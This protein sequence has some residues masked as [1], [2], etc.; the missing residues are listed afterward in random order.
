MVIVAGISV[1]VVFAL[2]Y[3]V[4]TTYTLRVRTDELSQSTRAVASG[5]AGSIAD[6]GSVQDELTCQLFRVEAGLIG[7][8]LAV[9]DPH[10]T[11]LYESS[12]GSRQMP[13][14]LALDAL[15]EPDEGDVL[16]DVVDVTGIGRVLV[17]A[18]PLAHDSGGYVVALKPVRELNS[19]RGMLALLLAVSAVVAVAVVWIVGGV[20]ARRLTAPLLRLRDATRAVEEGDWGHQVAVEGDQEIAQLAT[21]FNNM[22]GRV[23]RA[24]AAQKEFVGN[25]SHELKTPITSI[26]GFAGALMDGTVS[27]EDSRARY[28][29][30]IKEEADRLGE[31]SKTLLALADLDAG[32]AE[33]LS[34]DV[35]ADSLAETLRARHSGVAKEKSIY[36]DLDGLTDDLVSDGSR[37]LEAGSILVDNAIRHT[38]DGGTV[39]LTTT[40]G[41]G[42]WRL[43]VDDSGPGVPVE[44]RAKVFE[45]FVRLEESRSTHGGGAGLGL[46]ICARIAGLLEGEV[47]V[48]ESDLG[49]AQFVLEI[50]L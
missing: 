14:S 15:G 26:S 1:A 46:A 16:S 20:F 24:Y 33:V 32:T 8:S 38:P 40:T 43:A 22:S 11:V 25:V 9:T 6:D 50:P 42:S 10:G 18:A 48:C 34:E 45:R 35:S 5:L 29:R 28:Y 41:D 4:W 44:D 12:A 39:R 37:V 23:A 13:D 27:D 19:A 3:T 47:R 2:F 36:L 30:V 21:S 31:L 49:G 7:A 17:V